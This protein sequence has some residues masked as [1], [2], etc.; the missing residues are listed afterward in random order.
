MNN[1]YALFGYCWIILAKTINHNTLICD[2][3][4]LFFISINIGFLRISASARTNGLFARI[5]LRSHL[6][7]I[8]NNYI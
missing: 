8:F 7:F 1:L 5:N 3:E 2:F 6:I 4:I